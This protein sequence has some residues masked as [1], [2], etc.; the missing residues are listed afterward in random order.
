MMRGAV[1]SSR[2]TSRADLASVVCRACTVRTEGLLRRPSADFVVLQRA[3]APGSDYVEES[4]GGE[5]RSSRFPHFSL[6]GL[7]W[8]YRARRGDQLAG[9]TS[10]EE[11]AC[12]PQL[13]LT[14][15]LCC[16]WRERGLWEVPACF[17][18]REPCAR[19]RDGC[20]HGPGCL[21]RGVG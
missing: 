20:T 15:P 7:T 18:I 17:H 2:A 1:R 3:R 12:S 6:R 16:M 13:L 10:W 21:S 14:T 8:L 11:A 19:D 5:S 4:C 9:A